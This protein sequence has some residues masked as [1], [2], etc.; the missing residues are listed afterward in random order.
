MSTKIY[1][2][3]RIS[4][5]LS[6]VQLKTLMM[7]LRK[8]AH[9]II[10]KELW[11]LTAIEAVCLIDRIAM[12]KEVYSDWERPLIS[13][14]EDEIEKK[15]INIERTGRRDPEYDFHFSIGILPIKGKTLLMV[16][17][18]RESFFELIKKQRWIEE[19]GYWNNTDEPEGVSE[20]EWEQRKKDWDEALGESGIPSQNGFEV[21][22]SL[23]YLYYNRPTVDDLLKLVPTYEKRIDKWVRREAINEI[24]KIIKEEENETDMHSVI[25]ALDRINDPKYKNVKDE[26][27]G[28]LELLLPKEINR[29]LLMQKIPGKPIKENESFRDDDF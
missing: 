26:I 12:G 1:N 16:F 6:L 13:H 21:T 2:G 23:P 28:R 29:E 25:R 4:N 15:Y 22:L 10:K 8:H 18:E 19:Y 20:S 7:R 9:R 27:R 11:D 3:F 24:A 14:V 5:D 17:A